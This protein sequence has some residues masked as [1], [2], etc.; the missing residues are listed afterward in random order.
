MAWADLQLQAAE[1]RPVWARGLKPHGLGYCPATFMSRPVW[2]RGLKPRVDAN[3]CEARHVAPRVGAWIETFVL[4]ETKD[5]C[6]SRAPC[7]R[8]D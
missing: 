2:A 3:T 5:S 6:K 4:F 1:S 7:G 8:V